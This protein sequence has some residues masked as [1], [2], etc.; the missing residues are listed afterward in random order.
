MRLARGSERGA[1]GG[2]RPAHR[3]A[4]HPDLEAVAAGDTAEGPPEPGA[5][6]GG[7]EPRP[8]QSAAGGGGRKDAPRPGG[9]HQ[10][11]ARDDGRSTRADGGRQ[12]RELAGTGQSLEQVIHSL[13]IRTEG[14][15]GA[16]VPQICRVRRAPGPTL[17]RTGQPPASQNIPPGRGAERRGPPPPARLQSCQ[18]LEEAA[19]CP[20]C[21]A[22]RSLRV[23]CPLPVPSSA[24]DGV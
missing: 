19:W 11:Q 15:G 9:R 21:E 13:G 2:L 24:P 7:L 3:T 12:L 17:L 10:S 1:L 5:P 22:G 14:E 16:L 4:H 8:A 18:T 6:H 20:T 23:T